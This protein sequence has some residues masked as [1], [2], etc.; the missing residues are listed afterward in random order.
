MKKKLPLL[1]ITITLFFLF[2][3]SYAIDKEVL[4]T[5]LQTL[6]GDNLSWKLTVFKNLKKDMPC[7]EVK[8][9]YPQLET[10]QDTKDYDFPKVPESNHSLISGYEF[11]F[12]QGKLTDA[13]V[14]LKGDLDKETIKEISLELLQKKWGT[15]S[16]E[17]QKEDILTWVN[18]QFNISQRIFMID[19]WE[20]KNGLPK[21]EVQN[22]LQ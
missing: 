13:S 6:I 17:D 5:D 10:C 1:I 9:L 15:L 12:K 19:H 14:L 3:N 11:I 7:Q 4:K 2:Q 22:Q 16:A 20:I 8:T 21:Q 18:D